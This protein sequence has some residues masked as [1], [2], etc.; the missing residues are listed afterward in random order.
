MGYALAQVAKAKGAHVILI[1]GPTHIPPPHGT[2][3]IKVQTAEEMRHQVLLH[4]NQSSVV[5]MA[6]AVSDFRPAVSEQQKIKKKGKGWDLHLEPTGDILTEISKKT[7]EQL[8]IGFAAESENLISNARKKLNEKGL[9]LIIANDISLKD[10]GF[11][12]DYNIVSIID[13]HG[14]ISNLPRLPKIQIAEIIIDKIEE[15]LKSER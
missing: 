9:H 11:E 12:S 3:I 15:L 8:L 1:S 13:K 2:E 5:I 14:Q 6:S 10:S 4:L 7:S